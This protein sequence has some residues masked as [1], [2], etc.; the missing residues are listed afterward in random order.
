MFVKRD[1][2]LIGILL[3]LAAGGLLLRPFLRPSI[4]LPVQVA[5]ASLYVRYSIN[6]SEAAIIPLVAE[7]EIVIDQGEDQVNVLRLW[8]GGVEMKSSTCHNQLCVAQG[9]VTPEN[10]YDRP[11][12]HMLVCAPHRLVVELLDAAEAGEE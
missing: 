12:L 7:E 4:A 6:G 2:F 10:R 9:Q 8:P 5:E 3:A 11:L 1:I